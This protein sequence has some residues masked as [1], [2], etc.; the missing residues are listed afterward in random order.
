MP[1]TLRKKKKRQKTTKRRAVAKK[2]VSRRRT[3][4]PVPAP[5]TPQPL[6]TTTFRLPM[7]LIGE[8]RVAA[9]HRRN[10]FEQP[11]TQGGIVEAALR[12]WLASQ[13]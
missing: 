6:V 2:K 9:T 13:K 8:L 1:A 5:A 10:R 12:A 3:K 4:T 11:Y 7:D